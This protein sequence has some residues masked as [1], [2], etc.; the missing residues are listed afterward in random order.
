VSY[1]TITL[2][3]LML[4]VLFNCVGHG[5]NAAALGQGD[6]PIPLV[7]GTPV[8]RDV[9]GGETHTYTVG[10]EGGQFFKVVVRYD[11]VDLVLR[12]LSPEGKQLESFQDGA[13]FM[14]GFRQISIIASSTGIY[15]FEIQSTSE[16]SVSGHYSATVEQLRTATNEDQQLALATKAIIEACLMYDRKISP[17]SAEQ[18]VHKFEEAAALWHNVGDR[19]LEIFCIYMLGE[20]YRSFG[21][22]QRA[23]EGFKRALE[24]ARV[25]GDKKNEA[26]TL[27]SIGETYYYLSDYQ[28]ALDYLNLALPAYRAIGGDRMG[29]SAWALLDLGRVSEAIGERRKAIEY[30][31]QSAVLYQSITDNR[32]EQGRGTCASFAYLGGLY[33]SLGEKQKALEILD[34][35]IPFCR[36]AAETRLEGHVH[37]R[38]GAT[39]AS[40]GDGQ[41]ALDSYNRALTLWREALDTHNEAVAL[42]DIGR[43]FLSQRNLSPALDHL[44]Q[45]LSLR[46]KL[47]DR[48][49]QAYTLTLIGSAYAADGKWDKALTD[50]EEATEL[51]RAVGDQSGE[52]QTLNYMG[53][54]YH[55]MGSL[56]VAIDL[57]RKAL[58]IRQAVGDREGEASTLYDLARVQRDL[59][60]VL[61]AREDCRRAVE[62]VEDVRTSVASPELRAYFL[63][64]VQDYYELYIDLLIRLH[65]Q[66]PNSGYEGEALRVTERSRARSL[67]DLLAEAQPDIQQGVS[68]LLVERER[69]LRERINGK[70][71]YVRRLLS[72]KPA[73]DAT[74]A[75]SKEIE[76]LVNEYEDVRAQIHSTNPR[77]AS[78]TQPQPVGATEIQQELLDDQTL[79]LE[80]SLGRERSF[81]WCVTKNSI[82]VY[83]LPGRV[84]IEK[85]ALRLHES[86]TARNA[87]SRGETADHRRRRLA[88]ADAEYGEAAASLSQIILGPAASELGKKR[89]I[90]VPS[91]ALHF[92]PFGALRQSEPS[93]DV[94][95]KRQSDS[96]YLVEEHEILTLPSASTLAALRREV[97]FRGPGSRLVAVLADPVYS[98]DDDRVTMNQSGHHTNAVLSPIRNPT[99]AVTTSEVKRAFEDLGEPYLA[100]RIPRLFNTRW[101]AREIASLVPAGGILQA[102]DF[103]ASRATALSSALSEYKIVHFAAHSLIDNTHPELSGIVL[104]LVDQQGRPQDGFLRAH[105]IFNLKL[106]ADLVVLSGCR[107]GL[108]KEVRG[109]GLIGLTRAFMYAGAPRVVVSLWS[110]DDRA[111]A[112]LMVRFYRSMLGPRALSPAA[113]LR[114]AQ[115]E[116]I[117][118]RRWQ[119]PYY[120][121]G[122]VLQ[123]E[124]QQPFSK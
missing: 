78:L 36:Q 73:A 119:L 103:Q 40:L 21:E 90:I 93:R 124:W 97:A 55:S 32:I 24:I 83:E 8:H 67:L 101:E 7:V 15:R 53:E 25:S 54:S 44:N 71:E 37:D 58:A 9:H 118:E 89:L 43:V 79:L 96:K 5:F 62:I 16:S 115:I 20:T 98:A 66:D 26:V 13:A 61:E 41:R 50:Y 82:R 29:G 59:G 92:V 109:E 76:A 99:R 75:A 3:L 77:Y 14:P 23:L 38:I 80:Y 94:T 95:S 87:S 42:N 17:S 27:I 2:R 113:A 72:E 34:R 123:G 74:A 112:E 52:A 46:R 116:M 117:K 88:R 68:P 1:E 105:D 47:G 69:K 45:S 64:S 48:Q 63:A 60:N 57:Y 84:E 65:H 85:A 121:A 106:G 30:I 22:Y 18:I 108:G 122:F 114:S 91:G 28:K 11:G 49:G 6:K 10:I 81:L 31:E 107:T 86:L 51:W 19:H 39:L 35:A 4:V 12:L 33:S 102:L 104:S 70:A 110:Q 111:T 120:W 56:R 100:N